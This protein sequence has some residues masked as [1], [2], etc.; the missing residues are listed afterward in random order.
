MIL[1]NFA[2]QARALLDSLAKPQGSLGRIEEVAVVLARTQG[3]LSPITKKRRLVLFAADHGVVA[4]GVSAWPS[5]ITEMMIAAIIK[6]GA[7]SSVLAAETQTD[8]RLVDVGSL[9]DAP[10]SPPQF[11]RDARVRRSSR[12]L[13]IEP[14]LTQDEFNHCW[15]IG[16]EEARA[17]SVQGFC[18]LATGEMGIGNTTPAACLTALL[19]G[20]DVSLCVGR[21]AGADNVVLQRKHEI[22]QKAVAQN[23]SQLASN[24]LKSIAAVSGLEIAAMAGF[25]A[26]AAKLNCTVVLDGF[27]A[28]AAALIAEHLAPGTKHALLSG[29]QSAEPGHK[30]ALASLE[31]QP[32][33]S[34]DMRLGEGTGALVVMP[35]LDQAAAILTRMARLEDIGFARGV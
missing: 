19:T 1:N 29:H 18:V 6:G 7:A 24:P 16:A 20:S 12:D 8:L 23:K 33:L 15:E 21:G 26:E 35:L 30:L 28:T 3:T 34:F 31:L 32:V 25:L 14:A 13:S 9:G 5:A 2:L 27:V 17:A 11:Y 10:V 22:V 4:S